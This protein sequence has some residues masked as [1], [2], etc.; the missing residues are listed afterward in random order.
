MQKST[1]GVPILDSLNKLTDKIFSKK[2][3]GGKK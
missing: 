2:G 3:K 1:T